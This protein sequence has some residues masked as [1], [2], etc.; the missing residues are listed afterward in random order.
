[1]E[2]LI[3]NALPGAIRKDW[4]ALGGAFSSPNQFLCTGHSDQ[5]GVTKG[6][7]YSVIKEVRFPQ[8]KSYRPGPGY[9][10]MCCTGNISRALPNYVARMA[11][12]RCR[13][14]WAWP[15]RFTGR[16]RLTSA[17]GP[18]KTQVEIAE[19]TNYPYSEGN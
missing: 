11:D 15:R 14:K 17:V 9:V 13:R 12:V 7:P 3:F 2:R 1:M 5:L 18:R 19:E 16:A 4:K 6:W 8:R 10:I